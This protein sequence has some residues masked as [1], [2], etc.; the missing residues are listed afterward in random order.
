VIRWRGL[1]AG[2]LTTAIVA[3]P[4]SGFADVAAVNTEILYLRQLRQH[5]DPPSLMEVVPADDGIAGAR[6]ALQ[7]INITG[8]FLRRHFTMDTVQVSNATE[9]AA[10]LAKNPNHPVIV[11]DLDATLLLQLADLKAAASLVILDMATADD[12]LRQEQ[13]R[14]NVFHLL[15]NTAMRMDALGQFLVAKNWRRWFVLHGPDLNADAL[16]DIR[17]AAPRFGATIVDERSYSY[18]PGARRVDT[19]YQ[20]IQTQMPQATQSS[21][22]YDVLIVIDPD[23]VFGDYLPYNTFDARPVVG[24][25]GLVPLAWTPSY[26]EYSALQMQHRFGIAAHRFM[27]EADYGG[28]LAL[29]TVGEAVIRSGLTDAPGLHA[30]LRSPQF[31]VAGFKGQGLT[32]RSWDQQMRQPVLLASPLMV[33]SISP[34]EGFLN[35]TFLTDTLGFD[36]PESKCSK[37]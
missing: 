22:S 18:D 37:H 35:P 4:T 34:Q 15:P 23:D 36:A 21:H 12:V 7:E 1:L 24:T 27:D 31:E 8:G 10:A 17:R 9:I 28:W 33:V 19:G 11:A 26:Q 13:C 25:Q 32:F 5:P 3:A 6:L 16:R 14:P 20:Q 29:R 2:L 30:F